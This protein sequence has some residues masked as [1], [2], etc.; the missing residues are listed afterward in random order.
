MNR[1]ATMVQTV[2]RLS[3]IAKVQTTLLKLRPKG[4][5][6]VCVIDFYHTRDKIVNAFAQFEK[7]KG[8]SL[9]L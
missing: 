8:S 2:G 1:D 6:E 7:F 5:N 4:K 9:A 3:R